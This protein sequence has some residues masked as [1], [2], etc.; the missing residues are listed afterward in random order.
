MDSDTHFCVADGVA[1]KKVAPGYAA[2]NYYS[3]QRK[4]EIISL[5]VSSKEGIS[6]SHHEFGCCCK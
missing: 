3:S 4:F 2:T 6:E 5:L 1:F